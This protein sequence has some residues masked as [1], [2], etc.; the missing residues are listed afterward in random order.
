M[1]NLKLIILNVLTLIVFVM[2]F[3]ITLRFLEVDNCLD[4]GG[5]FDY[6]QGICINPREGFS[7][8]LWRNHFLLW[9]VI[10]TIS[11]IPTML[12]RKLLYFLGLNK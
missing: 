10:V 3:L 1:R 5:R 4:A 7:S 9:V 6:E 12:I 11:S 8:L 2:I